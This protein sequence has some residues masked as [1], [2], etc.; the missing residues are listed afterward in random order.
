[1]G[2]PIRILDLATQMIRRAGL[3][4]GEDIEIQF[5]GV[6]PGEKLYEE[7]SAD[8]EQTAATSHAKIRVWQ[9]PRASSEQ[10][11]QM[12]AMLAN[13]T[14]AP[15]DKVV[16]ALKRVLPGEYR[17]NGEIEERPEVPATLPLVPPDIA[18]A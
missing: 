2:Q 4:V 18:A 3:K 1:M 6:R 14:N 5:T 17:P 13:V 8:N 15:R 16:S 7:L 9:L 11:E 12:L 10:I